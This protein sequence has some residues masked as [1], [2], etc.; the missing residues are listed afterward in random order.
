M[1]AKTERQRKFMA[2]AASP[3]GRKKLRAEGRKVP[4]VK[5]AREFRRKK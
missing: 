3:K 2:M 1:P 4:A 5:V